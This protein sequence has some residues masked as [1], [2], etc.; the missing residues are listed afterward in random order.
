VPRLHTCDRVPLRRR[1]WRLPRV[2]GAPTLLM[3]FW[4]PYTYSGYRWQ[5]GMGCKAYAKANGWPAF[6]QVELAVLREALAGGAARPAIV[7]CGGGVVERVECVE[8]LAEGRQPVVWLRRS[9]CAMAPEWARRAA[10]PGAQEP[11]QAELEELFARRSPKYQRAC[12]QVQPP[13][14]APPPIVPVVPSPTHPV[15]PL[16]S[17]LLQ[18]VC[19]HGC[20]WPSCCCR[21]SWLRL[22]VCLAECRLASA[23][24]CPGGALLQRQRI[25]R[26]GGILGAGCGTGVC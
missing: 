3:Q 2:P 14:R 13:P 19:T 9:A 16:Q 17:P 6:R 18:A 26:A 8:L 5:V 10:L 24:V 15:A 22:G 20:R 12:G 4:T 1:L 7:S 11:T 21:L 23:Q 25:Q